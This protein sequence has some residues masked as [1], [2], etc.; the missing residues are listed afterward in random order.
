M[1]GATAPE[2]VLLVM[3]RVRLSL[4]AAACLLLT[5]AAPSVAA[6][7]RDP[8][9]NPG[10]A[11][12]E[13]EFLTGMVPH[14][15]GAIM[16][17][18]LAMQRSPHPEVRELAEKIIEDQQREIEEMSRFLLDWYG[19]EPPAGME[20]PMSSMMGMMPMLHGTMP[21]MTA[22]MHKLESLSGAEFDI[23]F[24]SAMTDHH[25]MAVMMATPVLIGGHHAELYELAETVVIS[26]GE[27]IKQMDEFLDRFYQV[28]RPLEGPAM[29]MMNH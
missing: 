13:T 27:E 19:M 5:M 14:H 26:Q 3:P 8:A 16:M 6:Q 2:G 9:P 29:P 12:I 20:M 24:L 25:A 15:R 22:R 23:E 17:A 18:E 7:G 4:V 10:A 11:R 1:P 28:Q 21:D